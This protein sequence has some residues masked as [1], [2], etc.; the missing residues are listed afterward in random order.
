MNWAAIWMTVFGTT[1]WMNIDIGFWM[2]M[3]ASVLV[4]VC[5]VIVFWS[6]KPFEK[7]K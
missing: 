5:M 3:G 7:K 6:M 4:A 2:S 1:T